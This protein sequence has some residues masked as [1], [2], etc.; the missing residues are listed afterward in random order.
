MDAVLATA[1]P[2]ATVLLARLSGPLETTDVGFLS[3]PPMETEPPPR[4]LA[5]T[6]A[7]TCAARSCCSR[8]LRM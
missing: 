4:R 6:S 2:L 7:A 1:V 5:A 8:Y 3:G